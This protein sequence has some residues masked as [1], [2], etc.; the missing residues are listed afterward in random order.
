MWLQFKD[1]VTTVIPITSNFSWQMSS[2]PNLDN[3]TAQLDQLKLEI[4]TLTHD[5][6]ENSNAFFLVTMA[7]IIFC[8]FAF[9]KQFNVCRLSVMQ[10]G[11]AFLG[12]LSNIWTRC[13]SASPISYQKFWLQRFGNKK[14]RISIANQD[15]R[16]QGN[17]FKHI[18][19]LL[20]GYFGIQLSSTIVKCWIVSFLICSPE[21]HRF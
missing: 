16:D 3:L 4:A 8:K 13:D 18:S 6:D 10:A 11:F 9:K 5:S 19:D 2:N 15:E 20:D 17:F 21:L 7:L 12:N 14:N 1:I